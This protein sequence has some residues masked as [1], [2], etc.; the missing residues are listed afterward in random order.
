MGSLLGVLL[1]YWLGNGL[2]TMMSNG[3]RRMDLEVRPDL[4]VLAFA[5]LVSLLACLLFSLAPAIQASR[6][7]FQPALAE[8]RA[9][10]WRLGKGLIVAQVAI[11]LM[12]LIGA[13]LF[14]RTLMNMYS[15]DAG[16]DRHG[17]L[18]FSVNTGRA[19]YKG[20]RLREVEGRII[21]EIQSL[22]GVTSA[23]L[24]WMPPISGGGWDGNVFVE[25]YTYA[26]GEDDI[27][28]LNAVGPHYFRT[29]GTPVLVGR[30]F[31]ERDT[32]TSP[33]LR[34]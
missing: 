34:L 3:G 23:S 10:R 9:G 18:M 8:I 17:V 15:L 19:G 25:G 11:S 28:H 20:Q 4:R 27:S 14:G 22:P 31:G 2:V 13:G 1:A 24:S 32:T 30:E 21:Q 6:A 12:L 33:R 16:F 5:S 26:P 7:S 29:L